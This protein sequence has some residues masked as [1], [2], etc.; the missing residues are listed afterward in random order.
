MHTYGWDQKESPA[1]ILGKLSLPQPSISLY[2]GTQRHLMLMLRRSWLHPRQK[3]RRDRPDCLRIT[4][5]K[6]VLE[7]HNLTLTEAVNMAQNCPLRRLLAASGAMHS[8]WYRPEM[9]MIMTRVLSS[10]HGELLYM[11]SGQEGHLLQCKQKP[12]NEVHNTKWLLLPSL[13]TLV[14]VNHQFI[15]HT[16]MKHLYHR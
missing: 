12:S 6:T 11:A 7:S 5:M 13:D 10:Y 16:V 14:N 1:F 3:T 8:Y 9:T 2:L 15:H 4:W